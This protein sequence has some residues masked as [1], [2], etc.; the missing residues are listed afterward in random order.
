MKNETLNGQK[1]DTISVCAIKVKKAQQ[2]HRE[3]NKDVCVIF[4]V[5]F[6]TV[7]IVNEAFLILYM[8]ALNLQVCSCLLATICIS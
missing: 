5:I 8:Y 2:L 3:K 1:D 4:I 6:F 7:L